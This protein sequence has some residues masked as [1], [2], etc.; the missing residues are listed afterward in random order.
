M[1]ERR[2][3]LSQEQQSLRVLS[4]VDAGRAFLIA[5]P[6]AHWS[7]RLTLMQTLWASRAPQERQTRSRDLGGGGHFG[8]VPAE[9][10]VPPINSFPCLLDQLGVNSNR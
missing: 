3:Q 4:P 10:Q 1:G 7:T 8:R 6:R 2:V 9:P 5:A